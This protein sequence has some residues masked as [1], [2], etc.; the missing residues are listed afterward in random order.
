MIVELLPAIAGHSVVY[1]VLNK[2]RK[3]PFEVQYRRN[4]WSCFA[5]FIFTDYKENL[6]L[7]DTILKVSGKILSYLNCDGVREDSLEYLILYSSCF[8]LFR[9]STVSVL[10]FE[11]HHTWFLCIKWKR[12]NTHTRNNSN[13]ILR[14]AFNR[15]L[16][17]I[18]FDT[19]LKDYWMR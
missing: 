8:G 2:I 9:H 12:L 5:S 17:L 3:V 11:H 4:Y 18:S 16:I 15:R 14:A 6:M 13:A 1:G 10:C 7:T 19:T